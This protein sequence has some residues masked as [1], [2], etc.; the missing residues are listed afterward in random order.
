MHIPDGYLV[1]KVWG[2]LDLVSAGTVAL[3]VRRAN[4]SLAPERIPLM[5]LPR[6][7]CSPRR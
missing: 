1:P 3:A 4:R 2:A 7:S 6:P 5:V